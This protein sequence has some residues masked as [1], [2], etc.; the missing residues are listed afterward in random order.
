LFKLATLC[1]ENGFT[2]NI[3][4]NMKTTT[5]NLGIGILVSLFLTLSTASFA[6]MKS[7]DGTHAKM[8]KHEMSEKKG[9][10]AHIKNL[11][12]DQKQKIE[13][14]EMTCKEDVLQLKSQMKEK[15]AHLATLEKADKADIAAI[16]ATIDEISA[17]IGTMMK[18]EAACKQDIRNLLTEKQRLQFDMHKDK[19]EMMHGKKHDMA[20]MH[21]EVKK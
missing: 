18:K 8:H 21:A 11:S 13:K 9:M 7:D 16:N 17:E 20:P 3:Y 19:R 10:C 12:D 14:I 15:K 2:I 1:C 4:I 5:K 6:Q